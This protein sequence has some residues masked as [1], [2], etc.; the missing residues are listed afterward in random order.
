MV[1]GG[2]LWFPM[3]RRSTQLNSFRSSVVFNF[4]EN[5]PPIVKGGGQRFSRVLTRCN[6][7]HPL[8]CESTQEVMHD[9]NCSLGALHPRGTR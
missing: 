1:Q 9:S 3:K 4:D 6:L 5:V 2:L 7:E 8:V